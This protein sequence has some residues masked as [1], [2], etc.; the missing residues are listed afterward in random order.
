M[1][2]YLPLLPVS[3][4]TSVFTTRTTNMVYYRYRCYRHNG[5]N[6]TMVQCICLPSC[7]LAVEFRCHFHMSEVIVKI[8][9]QVTT[10]V[11]TWNDVLGTHI[12]SLPLE[13]TCNE[14]KCH[15]DCVA[16]KLS[17]TVVLWCYHPEQKER[18]RKAKRFYG[19]LILLLCL[20]Q[21]GTH[22]G[23][24]TGTKHQTILLA[25]E[26]H[27]VGYN[28]KDELPWTSCVTWIET[29][30]ASC[31]SGRERSKLIP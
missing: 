29:K 18:S 20:F 8:W 31:C 21:S 23:Y 19:L 11:V 5:D 15:L 27:V 25:G 12:P 3:L 9:I 16:L 26:S 28:A 22:D 4:S 6:M 14:A 24:D 10:T 7:I 30:Q 13:V 1:I 17:V 2:A